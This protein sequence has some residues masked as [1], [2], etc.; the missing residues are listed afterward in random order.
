[1]PRAKKPVAEIAVEEPN[2]EILE[3]DQDKNSENSE[4]SVIERVV[5]KFQRVVTVKRILSDKQRAHLDLLAKNKKGKK[6]VAQVDETEVELPVVV[7]KKKPVVKEPVPKK[8][9]EKLVR[10]TSE[11]EESSEETS[12]TS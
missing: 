10:Y 6:Y 3:E 2:P 12:S 1:M 9:V 4:D 8:R 5:N 11:E 7:K